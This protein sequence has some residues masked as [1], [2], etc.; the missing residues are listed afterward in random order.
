MASAKE[1]FRFARNEGFVCER[2]GAS[3][4]PLSNGSCRNHCPECL[5]SKHVD[6]VPG[7]RAAVCG[8]LMECIAVEADARRGWMLVH[9]CT[10]CGIIRRNK[11]ALNDPRQPDRF[12]T[13]LRVASAIC[14]WKSQQSR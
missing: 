2:C 6:I 9:K 11:A 13:I 12:E 14:F 8:G 4:A 7:D 3:V 1:K 10:R 5:W